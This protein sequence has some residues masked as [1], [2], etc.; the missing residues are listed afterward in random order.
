[1]IYNILHSH[2]FNHVVYDLFHILAYFSVQVV[3]CHPQTS[4]V[5][6]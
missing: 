4:Q 3:E 6:V 2:A 1:L 5:Q